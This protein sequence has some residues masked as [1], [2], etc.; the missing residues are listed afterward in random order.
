MTLEELMNNAF[1]ETYFCVVTPDG[2][3]HVFWNADYLGWHPD[4]MPELE[5]LLTREFEEFELV[6]RDDPEKPDG[7]NADKVPMVYVALDKTS[8]DVRTDLKDLVKKMKTTTRAKRK[9]GKN[10]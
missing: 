1:D 10:T 3:E 2:E 4:V 8:E 6:I 9:K 5:P 7:M